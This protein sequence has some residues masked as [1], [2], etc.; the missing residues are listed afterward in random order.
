MDVSWFGMSEPD[1]LC[2]LPSTAFHPKAP[3][4]DEI[5]GNVKPGQSLKGWLTAQYRGGDPIRNEEVDWAASAARSDRRH[6][7]FDRLA[8]LLEAHTATA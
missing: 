2:Y 7:D 1:V 8:V 5:K 6:H 4:W 3:T